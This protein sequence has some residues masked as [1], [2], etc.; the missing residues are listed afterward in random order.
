MKAM[1]Q[2][3]QQQQQQPP[4]P[5]KQ[6]PP[7]PP[8]PS[9]R[10][11]VDPQPLRMSQEELEHHQNLVNK[12]RSQGGSGYYKNIAAAGSSYSI[13]DNTQVSC[14][15]H[16][17]GGGERDEQTPSSPKMINSQL[18][19]SMSS[20]RSSKDTLC[21]YLSTGSNHSPPTPIAGVHR[22]HSP[23]KSH[24]PQ[25]QQ[26]RGLPLEGYTNS[27]S[28]TEEDEISDSSSNETAD[29]VRPGEKYS[30]GDM[31]SILSKSTMSRADSEAGTTTSGSYVVDAEELC[32]EIDNLFF[33]EMI[34]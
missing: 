10:Q 23:T 27:A 21:S 1:Q 30:M 5:H 34:V 28:F 9:Q 12:Q 3:Q 14:G 17:S 25:Q 15:S 8:P 33:S 11:A 13:V 26:H 7:P 18:D 6:P 16:G 4:A 32:N 19:S 31:D 24:H 29:T 2:Q 20:D 22:P